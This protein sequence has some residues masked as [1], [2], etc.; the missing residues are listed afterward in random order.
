MGHY[1]L[2]GGAK[3][4]TG[5][6]ARILDNLFHQGYTITKLDSSNAYGERKLKRAM[7]AAKLICSQVA[8]FSLL[9]YGGPRIVR[10]RRL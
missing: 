3:L 1:R 6:L 7:E 5:I 10:N 4:G 2:E 8:S 9:K